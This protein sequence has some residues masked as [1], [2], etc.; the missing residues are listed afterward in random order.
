[1]EQWPCAVYT[2]CENPAREIEYHDWY[3]KTHIPDILK[4]PGFKRATRYEITNPSKGQGKYLALY[5]METE[6]VNKTVQLFKEAVDRL[7]VQGR[8]YT[9][10]TQ[11]VN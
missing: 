3:N 1:M 7:K 8:I 2:D 4:I 11:P 10:S 6:N 9:L 5:D